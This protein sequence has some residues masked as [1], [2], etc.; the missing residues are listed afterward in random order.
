MAAWTWQG[1]TCS[2]SAPKWSITSMALHGVAERLDPRLSS[3][4]RPRYT[5][6]PRPLVSRV[7][8]AIRERTSCAPGRRPHAKLAGT[9]PR[10][11]G[12]RRRRGAAR[13]ASSRTNQTSITSSTRPTAPTGSRTLHCRRTADAGRR[14]RRRQVSQPRTASRSPDAF[15]SQCDTG[16]GVPQERRRQS[17]QSML[18]STS[19]RATVLDVVGT[20]RLF[21]LR[22]QFGPIRLCRCT[23]TVLVDERGV[24]VSSAG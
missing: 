23:R 13:T 6:S 24:D 21:L 10:S 5:M 3:R 1:T 20:N 15:A 17:A 9:A 22:R 12:C 16:N 8:L 19:C 14:A 4:I 2:A 11:A 7:D 18:P